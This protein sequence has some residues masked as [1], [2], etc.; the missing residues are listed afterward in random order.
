LNN[1]DLSIVIVN[2]RSWQLLEQCLDS[3]A[4]FTP[5]LNHEIIVV[6]NDSQ[7]RKLK[8]FSKKYPKVNFIKNSGNNGFANGCNLGADN[9]QGVFLLFLNPDTILTGSNAIDSMFQFA[10]KN[11]NIGIT[12]CRRINP[13]G[14]PEREM[15]FANPWLIISWI[16]AIYK[17]TNKSDI[18]NKFPKKDDI[19]YP[20]WIAGSVVLI[21]AKLFYKVDKWNQENFW[22]YYEDVDLCRKVNNK[23]NN[24][25]LLRNV[26]LQHT[27]GGSSRKN[28][29]TT[30][31]TKSEVVTSSHVYI[32]LHTKGLNRLAL[33]FAIIVDTLLSQ[34]L[35]VIMTSLVFWKSSFKTNMLVLI[36]TIKYYIAAP[37]RGTW[38]SKRLNLNEQ[39][40]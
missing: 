25:A 40:R 13:K 9:A 30:A 35:R 28:P 38:K 36:N 5:K 4:K 14:K 27:H 6:D 31:I 3:F 7:D 19:W 10:K 21:K 17:I 12:S 1:V 24:I 34:V 29:K 39:K 26:E 23:N 16:R 11:H 18:E 8:P 2:Y 22:M 32:Q 37:A 20:N 15:A 33:H